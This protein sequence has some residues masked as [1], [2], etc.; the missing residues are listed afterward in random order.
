[1]PETTTTDS[2]GEMRLID[3][4][5]F[6][7]A[8]HTFKIAHPDSIKI[9]NELVWVLQHFTVPFD[10]LNSQETVDELH[11]AVEWLLNLGLMRPHEY[12][13]DGGYRHL[14][15]NSQYSHGSTVDT[16]LR[17]HDLKIPRRSKQTNP[18]WNIDNAM[19]NLKWQLEEVAPLLDHVFHNNIASGGLRMGWPATSFHW[20]VD[21]LTTV[22]LETSL[23]TLWALRHPDG[24]PKTALGHRFRK[25]WESLVDEHDSIIYHITK[26]PFTFNSLESRE[27]IE[28]D[29]KWTFDAIANDEWVE[30][31]YWYMGN[32]EK[33]RVAA[34]NHKFMI[35]L[36][37]FCVAIKVATGR[38]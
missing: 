20:T 1:M 5:A 11:E 19:G 16:I 34:P 21:I 22:V 26:Q 12:W 27:I 25:M 4:A 32:Q 38:L 29:V 15:L 2:T 18:H 28:R 7:D 35:A 23:K 14:L 8:L 24:N 3:H 10:S 17:V 37:V 9:V 30:S 13:C 36:A 31:R 33:P 6:S